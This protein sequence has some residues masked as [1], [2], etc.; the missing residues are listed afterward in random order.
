MC[1]M[2]VSDLLKKYPIISDQMTKERLAIVLEALEQV[3]Q[4]HVQGDIVEF[5]CYKGT[6]ALFLRRLLAIY[7]QSDER[8]LHVYD[9][10]VGLPEKSEPDASPAG[11][12]FKAGALAVS[13]KQLLYEFKKAQLQMPIIHKGWFN[14][15][16]TDA[17]PSHIAF[18][19]IDGDF[20][21]SIRDA[22]RLVRAVLGAG[23]VITVDDYG[24]E[25]LPGVERAVGEVLQDVPNAKFRVKHHVAIINL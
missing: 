18:A 11:I 12:Q 16:S 22:L 19:F 21:E 6:T 2:H 14:E 23:G 13:K 20:Y 17:V 4:L 1:S 9:S 25:A 10:F 7:D 5:G 15:L 3:L 24:R 8:A